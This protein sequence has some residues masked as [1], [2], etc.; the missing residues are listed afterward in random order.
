MGDRRMR[1]GLVVCLSV[2][3]VILAVPSAAS[4]AWQGSASGAGLGHAATV[5]PGAA[6]SAIVILRTV[7][8]A[9]APSTL[10]NGVLVTRYLV[11]RF[12]PSGVQQIIASGTCASM[13]L[14][15]TC[16]ETNVPVGD[17]LYSVT[18]AYENWRGPESTR[19]PV[20]VGLLSPTRSPATPKAS[21]ASTGSGPDDRTPGPVAGSATVI[22]VRDKTDHGRYTHISS[23]SPE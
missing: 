22:H 6:P 5:G 21:T 7:T 10:S 15:T 18:P 8:L 3:G 9:W 12:D 11:K 14:G 19:T 16:S 17:W 4:G 20:R 2:A 23:Y 13:V 1:R